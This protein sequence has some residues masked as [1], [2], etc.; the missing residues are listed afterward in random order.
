MDNCLNIKFFT[1]NTIS[2][3]IKDL[4]MMEREV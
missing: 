4:N 3:A 1:N 2:A